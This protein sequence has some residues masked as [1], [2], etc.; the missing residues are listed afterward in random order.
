MECLSFACTVCNTSI[1][2]VVLI[3]TFWLNWWF[4]W[5]RWCG[6]LAILCTMPA[7][8]D[9][10]CCFS[11]AVISA[12]RSSLS[13]WIVAS[14]VRHRR[15]HQLLCFLI[16]DIHPSGS[17]IPLPLL[18]VLGLRLWIASVPCKCTNVYQGP[19]LWAC[20]EMDE[21]YDNHKCL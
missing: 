6:W 14:M 10:K 16:V 8:K 12:F 4:R 21:V 1:L 2:L 7:V 19:V 11:P 9:V 15:A 17:F 20:P 3:A 5:L 18:T 13:S